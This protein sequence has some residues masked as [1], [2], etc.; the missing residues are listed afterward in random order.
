MNSEIESLNLQK[1]L[2]GKITSLGCSA[3]VG[4]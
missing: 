1:N 3:K 4:M 2:G